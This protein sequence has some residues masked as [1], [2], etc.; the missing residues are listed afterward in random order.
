M[1]IAHRTYLPTKVGC[2][3]KPDMPSVTGHPVEAL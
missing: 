3:V 1:T 2:K